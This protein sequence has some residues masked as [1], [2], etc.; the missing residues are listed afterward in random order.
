[1]GIL[2]MHVLEE[3]GGKGKEIEKKDGMIEVLE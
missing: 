3:A 2:S 1:V